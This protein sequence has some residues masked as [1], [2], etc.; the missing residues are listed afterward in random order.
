MVRCRDQWLDNRKENWKVWTLREYSKIIQLH[1]KRRSKDTRP[2]RTEKIQA[3][4][5]INNSCAALR[6]SKAQWIVAITFCWW[7]TKAWSKVIS[8]P[9]FN[10]RSSRLRTQSRLIWRNRRRR[11]SKVQTRNRTVTLRTSILQAT[12]PI[13]WTNHQLTRLTLESNPR[14][15]RHC[16]TPWSKT[17]VSRPKIL[18]R[19]WTGSSPSR[20]S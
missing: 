20:T 7:R 6:K 8:A 9:L 10:W 15:I 4:P 5:A 16:S 19:S 13:K 18:T 3:C 17:W 11:L 12:F 2:W 14:T 1:L